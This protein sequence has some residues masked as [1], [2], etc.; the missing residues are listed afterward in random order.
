M[1]NKEKILAGVRACITPNLAICQDCPYWNN[2]Q[3]QCEEL[4]MDIVEAIDTGVFAPQTLPKTAKWIPIMRT[5]KKFG[6][7]MVHSYY[8]SNCEGKQEVKTNYCSHCG[9]EMEE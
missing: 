6:V 7:E 4:R 9:A 1:L 3:R 5:N 8:C 2:G